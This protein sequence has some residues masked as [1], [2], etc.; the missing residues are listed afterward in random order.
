MNENIYRK[1]Y[2]TWASSPKFYGASQKFIRKIFPMAQ[3]PNV[4]S[5]GSVT[6]G[7]TKDLAS[8]L[9]AL[10]GKPS[11]MSRTQKNL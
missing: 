1:M 6:Y 3:C 5:I 7:V 2:P 10:V 4:S 11:T 9:K 8:I